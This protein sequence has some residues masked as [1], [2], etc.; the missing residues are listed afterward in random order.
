[1]EYTTGSVTFNEWVITRKIGQ[2]ATGKVY[3]IKKNGRDHDIRSVLKVVTIPPYNSIIDS[4]LN[5][6]MTRVDVVNYFK[7][8]LDKILYEIKIMIALRE[9]PNIVAYEG[10]CVLP[11][12]DGIGWDIL[13]KMERLMP[14]QEW[15]MECP[16]NETEVIRLGCE[17]SR[18]LMCMLDHNLIHRNIKPEN[19]FVDS[20]GTF[21]LGGFGV[22]TTIEDAINNPGKIGTESYMA[23][24]IYLGKKYNAKVDIYSLGVILYKFLNNNRPP[25]YPPIGEMITYSDR[26]KA[27]MKRIQGLPVSEPA[28]G[29]AELK[30]VVLKACEYLPENRY[31]NIS[32]LHDEL[33]KQNRHVNR[34]GSW[35]EVLQTRY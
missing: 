22:T 8:F 28:N 32:E 10:H 13:I 23:P 18:A 4:F 33:Q 16:M 12:E 31:V 19:I 27:L 24:E 35:T 20:S 30:A 1:M 15:Q 14:L 25:F 26:Q 29:S 17:I 6:G 7:E 21:K 3:E 11:H 5:E 34:N 2:G 9:H